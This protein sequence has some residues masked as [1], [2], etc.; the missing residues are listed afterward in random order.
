MCE[1]YRYIEIFRSS[2][3]EIHSQTGPKMRSS[4]SN[5]GRSAPYDRSDRFGGPNRMSGGPPMSRFSRYRSSYCARPFRYQDIF[6]VLESTSFVQMTMI[7]KI[8]A[9]MDTGTAVLDL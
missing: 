7:G 9:I 2:L 3:A 8:T 6:H 5:Y 4:V 1:L